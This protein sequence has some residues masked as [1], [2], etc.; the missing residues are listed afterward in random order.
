MARP[1]NAVPSV[2]I[3]LDGNVPTPAKGTRERVAYDWYL[4]NVKNRSAFPLAWQLLIAAL[5]GE[6][7]A[8]VKAAVT[9]GN[10]EEAID[11]LQD[12]LGQF[13]GQEVPEPDPAEVL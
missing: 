8:Q 5:N 7:G 2:R 11:A 12:L 10:T 6:L 4:E 13:G 1:K 3:R 9:D